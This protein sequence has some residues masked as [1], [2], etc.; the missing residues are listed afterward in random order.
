MAE[1]NNN[2]V[3]A[4]IDPNLTVVQAA[5]SAGQDPGQQQQQQQQYQQQQ[6]QAATTSQHQDGGAAQGNV[7]D[8]KQAGECVELAMRFRDSLAQNLDAAGQPFLWDFANVGEWP[9]ELFRLDCRRGPPYQI[10]LYGAKTSPNAVIDPLDEIFWQELY[11][12]ARRGVN[13]EISVIPRLIP[14]QPL[15]LQVAVRFMRIRNVHLLDGE[16]RETNAVSDDE[17]W[18]GFEENEEN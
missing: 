4:L 5:P 11:E 18:A 17:Y 7:V 12:V 9:R 2:P 14:I 6:Q 1:N 10:A 13:Q 15:Q 3:D 8:Q 16:M